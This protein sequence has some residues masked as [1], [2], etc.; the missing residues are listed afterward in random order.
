MKPDLS[1]RMDGLFCLE[2]IMPFVIEDVEK[3]KKGLSPE[4]AG[5]WVSIANDAYDSCMADGN[6]EK[7]GPLAIMTANSKVDEEKQAIESNLFIALS[8]GDLTEVKIL[9]PG[10]F[11]HD[12]YGKFEITEKDIDKAVKNWTEKNAVRFDENGNPQLPFSYQHAGHESDPEKSKASGWIKELFKKG[13]ELWAKVDWTPKAKEYLANKEFQYQS[14]EFTDNWDDE[15]GKSHGFTVTGATLTNY[16]HLKKNQLAIALTET[17]NVI[18]TC[19]EA[20]TKEAKDETIINLNNGVRAMEKELREI[21]G[22]TEGDIVAA[23]KALMEAKTALETANK[24]LTEQVQ[25]KE[26]E[27][28]EL[29]ENSKGKVVLTEAQYKELQDGAKAGFEV[30]KKMKRMEAEKVIDGYIAKGVVLP[31]QKD[32]SVN[33]F[34]MDEVNF[35]DFLKNAKPVINFTEQGS[36]TD[37]DK[38]ASELIADGAKKLMEEKKI[39]YDRAVKEFMASNKEIAKKYHSENEQ[40]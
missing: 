39:P 31:A 3:H 7:C 17:D 11:E 23:V 10:Y 22:L 38:S 36:S 25:A 12:Q 27:K 24:S 5:K 33:M 20:A 40:E 35:G 2:E 6:D 14:P 21:L 19:S 16:P 37:G 18:L 4:A 30:E 26:T 9:Y 29:M 15:S 13:K 34:L 32:K 28:K 8:E 1:E